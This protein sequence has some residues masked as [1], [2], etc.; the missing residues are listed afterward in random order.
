MREKVTR[1]RKR[2]IERLGFGRKG[3]G[4]KDRM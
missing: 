2:E 4:E 1:E 3:E